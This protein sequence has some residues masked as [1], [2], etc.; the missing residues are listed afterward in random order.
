[1]LSVSVSPRVRARVQVQSRANL[2]GGVLLGHAACLGSWVES[3]RQGTRVC[4][5]TCLCCARVSE[6]RAP[7][8]KCLLRTAH[9]APTVV[10]LSSPHPTSPL[11]QRL[12]P[13][14]TGGEG[15]G[16]GEFG[17]GSPYS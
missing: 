11:V 7:E 14:V 15:K 4:V 1:M 10:S 13:S 6:C 3:S 16:I 9:C 2:D 17:S 5:A 8:R 12:L